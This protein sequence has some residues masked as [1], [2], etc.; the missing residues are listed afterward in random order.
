MTPTTRS[1][2]FFNRQA[3]FRARLAD[4]EARTYKRDRD[5]QFSSTGGGDGGPRGIRDALAAPKTIGELETAAAGEFQ[6][7][8]G[9]RVGV[10]LRGLDLE[11]ARAHCEGVARGAEMFPKTD[12]ISVSSYGPGGAR[13]TA[14]HPD[15]AKVWGITT[16]TPG[17]PGADIAFNTRIT[18]DKLRDVT[19]RAV[20]A[21]VVQSDPTDISRT[22]SH[23][24]GHAAVAM[25]QPGRAQAAAAEAVRQR[26]GSDP[27][28]HVR[29]ELSGYAATSRDELI[30]EAVA[31]VAGR[32]SEASPLAQ[33]IVGE[34]QANWEYWKL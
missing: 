28:G 25:L 27:Y 16:S 6:R 19:R 31:Q 1:P 18:A 4:V 23:E 13:S 21:G 30:G 7:I 11:A 12:L 29:G 17:R 34:I 14:G 2:E 3:A 33:D 8:L 32:R 22:G 26:G 24:F 15:E 5:G 9:H 10:D 20:E